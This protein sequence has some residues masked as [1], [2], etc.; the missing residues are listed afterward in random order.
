MH[1]AHVKISFC[2]SFFCLPT[3]TCEVFVFSVVSPPASSYL[4]LLPP[5]ACHQP[6]VINRLSS[7]NNFHQPIAT[8]QLPP[9]TSHIFSPTNCHQ[10]IVNNQLS[11][12]SDLLANCG[13]VGLRR[14]AAVICVRG[15]QKQCVIGFCGRGRFQ[16]GQWQNA[17]T[18][19]FT[20]A[21]S[22]M[23]AAR[24]CIIGFFW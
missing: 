18:M 6:L 20:R 17:K 11:S 9:T 15:V 21:V 24:T 1:S 5:P 14:C 8:H 16:F 22:V 10:P 13:L 3:L 23:R 7:T 2:S 12:T 4:L 19:G